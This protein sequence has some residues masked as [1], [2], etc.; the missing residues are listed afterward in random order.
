MGKRGTV[1]V[2]ARLRRRFGI[3]EG[4]LV[5]TEERPDGILIRPAIALPVEIYTPER[6]AAFLLSNAVDAEDYRAAV[7]EVKRMGLEPARIPHA[8]KW[9]PETFKHVILSAAKNPSSIQLN[10]KTKEIGVGRAGLALPLPP[11]R[12]GGF[13][14][15]GSPVGGLTSE[16]IDRP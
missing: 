12:T 13:P 11:N 3:E 6:K 10:R 1:V 5:V 15:S 16:R 4:G 2:P 14:A 7:V 8:R 9:M